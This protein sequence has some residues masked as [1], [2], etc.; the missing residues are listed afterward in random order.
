MDGCLSTGG[1]GEREA[2]LECLCQKKSVEQR[3]F[4]ALS[5]HLLL[6]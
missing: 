1:A 6:E 4:E 3:D 2:A 5:E